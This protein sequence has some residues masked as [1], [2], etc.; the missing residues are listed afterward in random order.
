MLAVFAYGVS[1]INVCEDDLSYHEYMKN[2][3]PYMDAVAPEVLKEFMLKFTKFE[4][5]YVVSKVETENEMDKKRRFI[6]KHYSEFI[7][8]DNVYFTESLDKSDVIKNILDTKYKSLYTRHCLIDDN[9]NVLSKVQ[10]KG[11][12][13]VHISSFLTLMSLSERVDYSEIED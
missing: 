3:D 7:S 2:H 12:T 6:S 10:S 13:G 1:G 11:I 5:N 9:V 8:D 4:N